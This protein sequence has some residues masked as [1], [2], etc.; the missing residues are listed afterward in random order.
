VS[1][2]ITGEHRRYNRSQGVFYPED[3]KLHLRPLKG[4]WGAWEAGLRYS[5]VDLNDGTIQG[6]RE[7]NITAGLSWY[8]RKG[9]RVMI[10]YINANV[11]DRTYPP[12]IDNGTANI[13]QG[14]FQI[15][16]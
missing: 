2:F 3:E 11:K 6:G 4:E 5:Y 13:L 12:S 1:Y 8:N 15:V 16:F 7:S 14:R 10:N 9:I